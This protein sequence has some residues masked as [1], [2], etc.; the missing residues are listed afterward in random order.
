MIWNKILRVIK[1]SL[2]QTKTISQIQKTLKMLSF[3]KKKTEKKAKWE[4][5]VRKMT[6]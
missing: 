6:E 1:D 3:K 4:E 2:I 5:Q